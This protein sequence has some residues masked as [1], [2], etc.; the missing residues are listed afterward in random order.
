VT[1]TSSQLIDSGKR[2]RDRIAVRVARRSLEGEAGVANFKAMP[3][4]NEKKQP[5][6]DQGNAIEDETREPE[7]REAESPEGV[8]AE[9]S[10]LA[11]EYPDGGEPAR[12]KS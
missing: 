9:E 10:T 8:T 4:A 6:K 1:S 2:R 5:G 11:E 7:S 3:N 12:K